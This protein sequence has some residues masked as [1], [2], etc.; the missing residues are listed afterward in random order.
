MSESSKQFTT[1]FINIEEKRVIIPFCQ[2][3]KQR[4]LL[5]VIIRECGHIQCE[6]CFTDYLQSTKGSTCRPS[7]TV[8]SYEFHNVDTETETMEY[9]LKRIQ[10]QVNKK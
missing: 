6:Q 10:E 7:C 3:C 8:C 5:S 1:D 9:R 4:A 2:V